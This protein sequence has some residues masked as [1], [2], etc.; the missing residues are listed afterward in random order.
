M[1][2]SPTGEICFLLD[3]EG[4]LIVFQEKGASWSGVLAFTSEEK[5]REF[6]RQS[7]L[8]AAE[9][10]SIATDDPAAVAAL[11]G[12]IKRRAVRNLLLDLDYKTGLCTQV[13]FEDDRLGAA[14]ERQFTPAERH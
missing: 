9:L 13:E 1:K 6:C 3:S 4:A 10:G 8:D 7:N 12:S 14:T 2:S 11:V 5:A